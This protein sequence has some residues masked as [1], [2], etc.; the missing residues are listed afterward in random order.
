MRGGH[1][2]AYTITTLLILQLVTFIVYTINAQQTPF[3]LNSFSYKSS[4]NTNT[5][6]PGS[7]NVVLTVNVLYNGSSTAYVS[8]GCIVLPQGFSVTRGYSSCSPPQTANGSTYSILEPGDIIVFEYHIDVDSSVNPGAYSANLTIYYRIGTSMYSETL[9]GIT[10]NVSPYP[11]INVVVVDWYWS[12][13]AYPGSQGVYLYI[14]IRNSGNSSIAQA[15]GVAQLPQDAFTPSSI[16]FQIS[17]LGKNQTTTVSL[18]PV[19]VYTT[20]SPG[21]QYPVT[22]KLNATMSTD[23]NVVYYAQGTTTFYVTVSQAPQVSI[24]IVD[25]GLE[26]PKP[27]Q[28]AVGTRF[29][30]TIVNKDFKNIRSITAYFTIQSG[31]ASFYNS[32]ATAVTIFQQTLGYG[33]VATIYSPPIILG[34][35]SQVTVS[36]KLIIFGD[37]NGAEFWSTQIYTFYVRPQTPSVNL[38]VT[39]VYWTSG[40]VYPG[41]EGATLNIVLQNYD[42]VN[43]RSATATLQ[44]P[45][46]LYPSTITASGIAIQSGSTTTLSFSGISIQ[47]NVVG[48]DYPAKLTIDGI[49]YDPSTNTFY[50]FSSVYTLTV[51]IS[52]KPSID[53]INL[54]SSGWVE[55]KAYTTSVGVHAYVYLQVSSPGFSVEGVRITAYLPN[56]M[57][58]ENGNR[59][60]V[61]V[62]GNN[63][64]SYGQ[65]LYVELGPIDVV[66][67]ADGLYPVVLRIDFLATSSR[68]GSFW[69]SKFY[70]ILLPVYKPMLNISLI[71]YGW[72]N[73]PTGSEAGG[74]S[75]YATLQSLSVD[76][77]QSVAAR[78]ELS[79]ARFLSG[80]N[81]SWET[82][83]NVIGY[84]SIYSLSFRDIEI[85]N[86]SNVTVRLSI[87]AVLS[88]GRNSFYRASIEYRFAL[89]TIANTS[90]FKVVALHTSIGNVYAPILPSARGVA[91]VI[92]IAN[93]KTY[94]VAWVKPEAMLPKEFKLNDLS[95]SCLNG[96]A[97]GGIC[98]ISLNVDVAENASPGSRNITLVLVYAIRSGQ[99][100]SVFRERIALPIA[101]ASYSYYRPAIEIVSAYWGTQTPVRALVGQRNIPFTISIVNRGYYPVEGVYI[102]AKPL[103]SSI[104][105]VKDSDMC[106]PRLDPGTSC[107]VT[108]YADLANVNVG[109]IVFFDININYSFAYYGANI[110]DSNYF[111]LSLPI[112]VPASGKGLEIVDVSWNN[113]WPVYP[114]TENATLVITIA[115]RWPYR[116]SGLD[117]ELDLPR[118]FYTKYGSIAKTYVAG[119]INSLQQF[120]VS[121]QISVA[122]VSPGRYNAVLI[123]RYVVESGSPNT[124]VVERYNVTLQVN[125]LGKSISLVS[126]QWIGKAP[127]PPEY[128]AVLMV[129]LRNNYNPSMRG[130]V[131]C[132]DLPYGFTSSDTNTSKVCVPASNINIVQQIQGASV[133]NPIVQQYIA[134]LIQ[135]AVAPTAQGQGFGYGD[136][137]YFYIK[138]NIATN[139]TGTFVSNAS[140]NFV[141]QWNNVRSIPLQINI[142]LLGSAK[143]INIFAPTTVTVSKG[144]AT[145]DIGILN[146]GSAPLYNV[147]VYLVPYAS[148]LIPQQAVKYIDLLPPSRIINVSYELVYNPVSV[149]LGG[150]AQ[151][152]LRYMSVPF[153]IS[154]LYRDVYGNT[155]F[156]NTSIAVLIQPFIDI[157]LLDTKATLSGN[158]LAVSGTVANYGIASARSVVVRAT[159]G[160]SYGETLVGDI[161]PASQSAFR[162]EMEVKSSTERN[163]LIEII[164]R[165]DYGR[166]N[167]DNYTIPLLVQATETVV[168]TPQQA[169]PIYNHYIVIAIV[170]AF[171]ATIGYFLYRYMKAHA[172]AIEKVIGG[173][174]SR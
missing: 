111:R 107:S 100:I 1:V 27:M 104:A 81:F 76:D 140:L 172:K 158:T 98:T 125:D 161:D 36:A 150:G 88:N 41:T 15:N 146:T 53:I 65:S 4:A 79:G 124:P 136:I 171:L 73:Q 102:Y 115:N 167:V 19:S 40:E 121:F 90:T 77:I 164:Y 139:K 152:Y 122:N 71:D 80:R 91:I 5:I 9:G 174:E 67:D 50:N 43:V 46:G 144:V 23:D 113:N 69:S 123:A 147:Y 33:D 3:V 110:H 159:Y 51:R 8:A 143:I 103:N 61:L 99:T 6:Y 70:T 134:S 10:I 133:A 14:T 97:S 157:V 116:V 30:M 54:T 119:P 118:G 154:I 135:Q 117:L 165:D 105:M 156:F 84:G 57:I 60:T 96:V 168:T 38:V 142:N 78:V 21:T 128:G 17:N 66:S 92:D 48:G 83:N 120:S 28:N 162:I 63:V 24:E 149:A 94:Q 86:N 22:L 44:L 126:I 47:T 137:M 13:D 49:A 106:S 32:T 56:E 95:G 45:S 89:N 34:S 129:S 173:V 132:L 145:L 160:D 20:A 87:Y 112:D 59:S 42:V 68:G 55:N 138:L 31:G 82:I 155:Q 64:Y 72:E 101:I 37:S 148:M 163:V 141:D 52:G 170:A 153:S 62:L 58:F 130:V 7:R 74:A 25:Y 16:R 11:Q 18:G 109:G 26:T 85:D 169:T 166:I 127:Q 108:L 2:I 131:L 12:P 75:L 39:D 151:T 35:A 114:D 93:T 29:Y